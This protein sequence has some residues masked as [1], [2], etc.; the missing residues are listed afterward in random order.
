VEVKWLP[1]NILLFFCSGPPSPGS[2]STPTPESDDIFLENPVDILD[3]ANY[4]NAIHVTNK[5]VQDNVSYWMQK[6]SDCILMLNDIKGLL[7]MYSAGELHNTLCDMLKNLPEASTPPPVPQLLHHIPQLPEKRDHNKRKRKAAPTEIY[8]EMKS[9]YRHEEPQMAK[10]ALIPTTENTDVMDMSNMEEC[11][12]NCHGIMKEV[13]NL[14]LYN[15]ANFGN[16]L[17]LAFNQFQC[18]KRSGKILWPNFATWVKQRCELSNFWATELRHFYMLTSQY[19]QILFCRLSFSF[20]QKNRKEILSYLG[21]HIE[22]G[23]K[24]KHAVSCTCNHCGPM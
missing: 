17:E 22:L 3:A 8:H 1:N 14:T 19:P 2:V 11:I 12:R 23:L 9:S 5:L 20:F 24:W 18:D 16:W 15:A 13:E 4:E 10:Q 7:S 21:S 6:Y